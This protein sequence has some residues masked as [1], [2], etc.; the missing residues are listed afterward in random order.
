MFNSKDFVDMSFIKDNSKLTLVDLD[1]F[2][3][4][5]MN[6]IYFEYRLVYAFIGQ[7]HKTCMHNI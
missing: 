7:T 4:T 3:K 2:I 1:L 5:E 6:R